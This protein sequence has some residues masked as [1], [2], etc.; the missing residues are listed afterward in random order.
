MLM[1]YEVLEAVSQQMEQIGQAWEV[2]VVEPTEQF[3][4]ALPEAEAVELLELL[5]LIYQ[6]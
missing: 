2:P 6:A 5:V 4:Q 1:A 3:Y